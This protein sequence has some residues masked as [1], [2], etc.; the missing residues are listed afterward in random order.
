MILAFLSI[1]CESD[2]F[3]VVP[4]DSEARGMKNGLIKVTG[5]EDTWS[6]TITTEEDLKEYFHLEFDDIYDYIKSYTVTITWKG[7]KQEDVLPILLNA[8]G[9]HE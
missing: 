3:Y 6:P 5:L 4:K 8:G 7:G 1:S 9:L 2:P